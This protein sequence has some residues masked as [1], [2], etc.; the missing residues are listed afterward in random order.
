MDV[1]KRNGI[2]MLLIFAVFLEVLVVVLAFC[3]TGS[4]AA[5][6]G[7][8]TGLINASFL[9]GLTLAATVLL[10]FV[11]PGPKTP[12]L[13]YRRGGTSLGRTLYYGLAV[14]VIL[15]LFRAALLV[16]LHF[17]GTEF[18]TMLPTSLIRE[19]PFAA[20]ARAVVALAAAYLFFGYV[21]GFVGGA[22][23]RRAGLTAAATLA[24]TTAIWP[25]VGGAHW[26]GGHPAWFA[27]LVWRLPEALA[28]AY[29]YERTRNV[30]APLVAVLL[31]E[32]LGAIGVGIYAISG[33]WAFTFL[34]SSAIIFL[35]AVGILAAERGR[36]FQAVGGFFA[37][38]FGRSPDAG[39]LDA[40]LFAAA[41]AASYSLVRALD[42][43]ESRV[44][45]A[46]LLVAVLLAGAVALWLL[47]RARGP[48]PKTPALE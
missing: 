27:F 15:T 11:L 10:R 43:I 31:I 13:F 14:A 37:L 3:P 35:A 45:V 5:M 46:P 23:G 30:L 26:L 22:L 21:Q 17:T 20:M 7:A 8:P 40:I 9:F 44:I 38:L 48:R 36:A 34:F 29:L 18:A 19:G 4:L 16:A 1:D 33:R 2:S 6:R 41:L 39:F 47:A 32:W 28:L 42:L 25:A 12:S 24:A